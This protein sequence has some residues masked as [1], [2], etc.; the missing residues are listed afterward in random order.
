MDFIETRPLSGFP[1]GHAA[2]IVS[3]G[4]LLA[5]VQEAPRFPGLPDYPEVARWMLQGVEAA[6]LVKPGLLAPHLERLA[7]IR[8][9]L[10]WNRDR[11]VPTHNDPNPR[12]LL[13]DG[14]RLWL[15]DW[16]L[17]AMNDPLVDVA[18]GATEYAETPELEDLLLRSTFGRTPDD[19]LRARLAVVRLLTRV[20]YGAIVLDS[21]K[22][23]LPAQAD[24]SLDALTP[25]GF[26]AAVAEGRYVSG[27]PDIAYAFAKMQ[28]AAFLEG[29]RAPGFEETLT[30]AAAA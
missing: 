22:G 4:D 16:E 23:R 13:F 14:Q 20:F 6:G 2:F 17:G 24:G 8:A 26:R 29:V 9:R 25:Q 30:R 27:S 1:G 12:N 7:H 19:N 10:P 11:F 15:V 18:I 5:R 21:L 28:L 3:F